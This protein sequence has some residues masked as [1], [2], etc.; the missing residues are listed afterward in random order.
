LK[1]AALITFPVIYSIN[2]APVVCLT[3]DRW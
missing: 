2:F 1:N 3:N